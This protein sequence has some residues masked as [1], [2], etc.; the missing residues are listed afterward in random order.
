MPE[1]GI[2]LAADRFAK[3]DALPLITRR[4]GGEVAIAAG[5]VRHVFGQAL[6]VVRKAAAGE[7]HRTGPNLYPAVVAA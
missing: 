1:R 4:R 5:G 7:D 2:K 6:S 3:A